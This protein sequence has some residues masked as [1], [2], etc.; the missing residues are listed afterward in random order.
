MAEFA[1][2]VLGAQTATILFAHDIDY[3]IGLRDSFVERASEIGLTI[4]REE[5]FSDETPD[6][7]AQLTNLAAANA[8]VIFI[9][10]YNR[11]TALIGPQS[12]AAGLTSTMLG[13]DGWA[14]TLDR[15]ADASTVE[16][17]FY[18][19]G[20][21]YE[22]ED[23]HIIEFIERFEATYDLMPNMF[24]AQAYDA[25]SILIAALQK[26]VA[27]GLEPGSTEF[28]AATIAH[29]AATDMHGVTGHITFDRYNNPQ[30]TA[31]ILQIRDGEARFWGTF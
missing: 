18:L 25:A 22:S 29:M 2:E 23:A 16:G 26:A 8:D 31:F 6:F 15:I 24:A 4:L 30:K 27:D 19:T 9:P 12:V 1:V 11:H 3:S 28:K 10:V 21:T 7:T 20:F 13:A 14:G 17:A 5:T